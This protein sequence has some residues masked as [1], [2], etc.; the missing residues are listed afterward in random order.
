[1]KYKLN[2]LL[3]FSIYILSFSACEFI[4]KPD[5]S[6]THKKPDQSSATCNTD[7]EC[8]L[9]DETCCGCRNGGISVAIHKSLADSHNRA[10]QNKCKAGRLFC[11]AWYRCEDFQAQCSHSKCVAIKKTN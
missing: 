3:I 7:A 4:G 1:M 5:Q 6:S 8:V 11:P 2:W 10:L 9:V